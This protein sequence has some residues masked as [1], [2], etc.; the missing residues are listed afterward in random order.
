MNG[1][2]KVALNRPFDGNV[3]CLCCIIS[4]F[5][6]QFDVTIF[7]GGIKSQCT[8]LLQSKYKDLKQEL[9]KTADQIP[10]VQPSVEA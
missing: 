4:N 3:K 1:D 6:L 10:D 7:Y 5:L 8:N 2:N 9:L